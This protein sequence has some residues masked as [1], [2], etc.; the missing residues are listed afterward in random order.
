MIKLLRCDDRLIHGQC[1]TKLISYY[2]VQDI[3]VVDDFIASSSVMKRIF[4]G[5]VPKGQTGIIVNRQDAVEK[6]VQAMNN[7][8]NTIVL[9]RTPDTMLRLYQAIPDLMKEYNIASVP[10][11]AGKTEVT[12]FTYLT[13]EQMNAVKQ[14]DAMGVHIWFQLVPDSAKYEWKQLCSNF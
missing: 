14:M 6:I 5:A 3:I 10:A 8:R 13:E 12:S 1:V 4:E 9:M 11:G 7:D 2:D